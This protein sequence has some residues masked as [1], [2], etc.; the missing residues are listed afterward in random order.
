M[1]KAN[2]TFIFTE[3]C[4]YIFTKNLSNQ[5]KSTFS[6]VMTLLLWSS[7]SPASAWKS[8]S[9]ESEVSGRN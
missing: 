8:E 1:L 4:T 7:V 3:M 2:T 9:E 5:D 6:K